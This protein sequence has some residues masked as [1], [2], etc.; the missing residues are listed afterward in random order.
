METS[1]SDSLSRSK[2]RFIW[3]DAQRGSS[4]SDLNNDNEN[5]QRKQRISSRS[6]KNSREIGVEKTLKR[7]ESLTSR[8]ESI[9]THANNKAGMSSGV[10]SASKG[11]AR[12]NSATDNMGTSSNAEAKT[13]KKK[14]KAKHI[15]KLN[16]ENHA[17]CAKFQSDAECKEME[18]ETK[19]RT[20]VKKKRKSKE[21]TSPSI[22]S[23][24]L[25]SIK[26]REPS[27][28]YK[29]EEESQADPNV[30]TAR[31]GC[32]EKDDNHRQKK[33]KSS[34]KEAKKNKQKHDSEQEKTS[35]ADGK[36][37]EMKIPSMRKQGLQEE[38]ELDKSTRKHKR[39]KKRKCK[40]NTVEEEGRFTNITKDDA[41]GSTMENIPL[42]PAD[43]T[44]TKSSNN[45]SVVDTTACR[46]RKRKEKR[47]SR[48]IGNIT[49]EPNEDEENNASEKSGKKKTPSIKC[50]LT[51]AL[52]VGPAESPADQNKDQ[53]VVNISV[54]TSHLSHIAANKNERQSSNSLKIDF[55]ESKNRK[56]QVSSDTGGNF[57]NSNIAKR[58]NA[59][60]AVDTT[61]SEKKG[62]LKKRCH[63]TSDETVQAEK[64]L[65]SNRLQH[66]ME[67]RCQ[68]LDVS[69][70]QPH[71]TQGNEYSLN[72]K[73]EDE[74]AVKSGQPGKHGKKSRK[75]KVAPL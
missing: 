13:S 58:K 7:K 59:Q 21:K 8:K 15:K 4:C 12:D 16:H 36:V 68:P 62:K 5:V 25:N 35:L 64:G 19:K 18:F 65:K 52:R 47:R 69:P 41:L 14:S 33:K 1:S 6:L 55:D 71:D 34:H 38:T 17:S 29:S 70:C 9:E 73:G 67:N 51:K 32:R 54:D 60:S 28:D 37:E 42:E 11:S 40:I 27:L 39:S 10:H 20:K 3:K 26:I 31:E 30:G 48:K 50:K 53:P 72:L 2:I 22:K 24:A 63:N 56:F 23:E 75:K 74:S 57:S 46:E 43:P 66:S 45:P 49:V 44:S 61:L